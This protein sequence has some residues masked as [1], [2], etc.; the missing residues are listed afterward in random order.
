MH[1][2]DSCIVNALETQTIEVKMASFKRPLLKLRSSEP[3]VFVTRWQGGAKVSEWVPDT[4]KHIIPSGTPGVVGEI[5]DLMNK[6]PP[7]AWRKTPWSPPY[8]YDF[9]ARKMIHEKDQE[10]YI[11]KCEEWIKDHPPKVYNE[12]PKPPPYDYEM[13]AKFFQGKTTTPPLE[14]RVE[15]FRAAGIPEKRIQKHIE[16]AAKMAETVEARQKSV[17]DIFGRYAGA[18]TKVVKAKPKVIKPVKKKMT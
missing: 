6:G 11:A 10:A 13:V 7:P 8:D 9:Y 4:R 15:V 5:V 17:D 12:K 2:K 1:T 16:W 18:K 14:D 3:L